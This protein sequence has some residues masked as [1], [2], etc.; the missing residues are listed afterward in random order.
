MTAERLRVVTRDPIHDVAL[1]RAED[2]EAVCAWASGNGMVV[3]VASGRRLRIRATPDHARA[4]G[5]LRAVAAVAEWT[6]PR[7]VPDHVA[8][9]VWG[10][11]PPR[12]APSRGT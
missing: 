11:G 5:E 9:I 3:L 12:C 6:P 7:L 10:A 1:H 4:L 2:L 8:R